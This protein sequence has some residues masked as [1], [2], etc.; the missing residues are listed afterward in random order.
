[1][2]AN[3]ITAIVLLACIILVSKPSISLKP[4]YISFQSPWI[5]IAVLFFV[6]GLMCYGYGTFTQGRKYQLN[7]SIETLK[8]QIKDNEEANH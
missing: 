1:M 3:L 4:F 6:L 5:G 2:R 8:Q 7:R